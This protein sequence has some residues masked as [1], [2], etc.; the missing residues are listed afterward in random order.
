MLAPRT[1]FIPDAPPP[2][3]RQRLAHLVDKASLQVVDR[4]FMQ[5]RREVSGLERGI[6]VASNWRRL[7]FGYT[8]YAPSMIPK[9]LDIHRAYCNWIQVGGGGLTRAQRFGAAKRNIRHQDIIY[10]Q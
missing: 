3:E 2:A 6:A 8:S 1:R 4:Y 9:F 5:I 7:W 10:Y